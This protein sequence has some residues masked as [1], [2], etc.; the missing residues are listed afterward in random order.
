MAGAYG[1]TCSTSNRKRPPRSFAESLRLTPALLPPLLAAG[2]FAVFG[3]MIRR[4]AN[5]R[6]A[7]GKALILY[8]L[9]WLIVYDS[10]FVAGYV[11][12]WMG[13]G[14]LVLWPV[15]YLAVR[16]MR[17]WAVMTDL[18]RKPEYIRAE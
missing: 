11:D 6:R 10:L 18:A 7:A 12:W 2:A 4:R 17:V 8:G 3:Y 1:R 9:L 5:D 13:A 15:A 16:A 14:L